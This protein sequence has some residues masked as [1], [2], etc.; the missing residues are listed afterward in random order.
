MLFLSS[1]FAHG[2]GRSGDIAAAQPKAA[3][4]SIVAQLTNSLLLD[5]IRHAGKSSYISP[6][7]VP[8]LLPLLLLSPQ[9]QNLF[10]CSGVHS[11]QKCAL[12]PVATGMAMLLVL[13]TLKQKRLGAQYVLWP[14][15]DQKTC[16]KCIVSA[17]VWIHVYIMYMS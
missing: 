2:V 5:T 16:F 17:G 10:L 1:R 6:P 9:S 11:A 8:S 12:L 15:I 4:S 14:R 13:L 3:G 7:T